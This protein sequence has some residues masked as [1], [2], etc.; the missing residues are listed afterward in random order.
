MTRQWQAIARILLAG[1][2]VGTAVLAGPAPGAAAQPAPAPPARAGADTSLLD[3]LPADVAD[4]MTAQRPL[5]DAASVVRTAIDRGN[6]T[7]YA[8]IGLVDDHVT[9][10]WKGQLPADVATAVTRARK[11]A[12]VELA[13]ATYSRTELRAAAATL[14]PAVRASAAKPT[15]RLRTDGAGLELAVAGTPSAARLPKLPAT[16]VRTTVVQRRP[17]VDRSREDDT[18]PWTG[19]ARIW[20]GGIGCS[21]AFGARHAGTGAGYLLT[22]GHCGNLGAVWTTGSGNAVGP[23]VWKNSDHDAMLIST[24][25]PGGD[26]YVGGSNDEV[27][28]RVVG[29][30][31]VFPGQLLCQSGATSAWELSRPI[32]NFR[33]EFHY[34][35][36]EDLV[37]ATQLA[38]EEAARGGDSGGPVYAVNPDGTVLAAGTLTRSGGP[39]LG[40]Q[41]FATYRDDFGDLVPVTGTASSTCRISYAVTDS[42]SGGFAAS[43]TV[44]NSG[45]AISGWSLRWSFPGNQVV[46]GRWH[47][48]F[49]QSGPAVLVTNEAHNATIPAGGSVNLG[50]TASGSPVTPVPFTLNGAPCS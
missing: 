36:R 40:F 37:E 10:W 7:G 11:T 47:G 44:H 34:D 2:L 14:A 42:W 20:D 46:Q 32:C 18:A 41:D 43:V 22:A 3:L 4:R 19:G 38:G 1:G 28:A 29:W 24:S 13:A 30:T 5:V 39:G 49:Q 31:Q 12:P 9:L 27:R 48:Q 21:S 6:A 33:V 16:G 8:G 35:D 45:P 23:A 15:V 25:T 50:F 17:M 26:I